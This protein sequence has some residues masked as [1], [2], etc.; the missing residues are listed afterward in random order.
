[1]EY[2]ILGALKK[3]KRIRPVRFHMPG[4]QANRRLFSFFKDLSMDITELSFSDCLEN[5]DG[6]IA[7]AEQEIAEILGARRSFIVTDGSSAAVFAMLFAARRFGSKIVIC[8]NS[9]KSVYNACALLGIEPYILK[10]NELDGVL[11]PPTP[12]DVEEAFKK[13]S[14]VCGV[15]LTSPD[16][17]G[18]IAEYE[19]IRKI[20]EKHKKLLMVDGAHGAYLKFDADSGSQAV[21]ASYAGD[22]ADIWVDG[23]HKTLPTLTQG[24]LLNVNNE[25]LIPVA[26]EG[27]GFFRT[28]SPSYPIMASVEYGVKFMAENGARLIDCI[29]RELT[30]VK[31]RLEKKGILFYKGS[32]TLQFAVD[33]GGMGISP[34]LAQEELEKR[35]FFAELNDGRYLV[36]YLTAATST[37]KLNRLERAI[38]RLVRGKT[39]KNTYSPKP[40]YVCGVKKFSY[41]T[42]L[43][44]AVQEV[45]LEKAVGKVCARNVGVT[46]PCYPLAIA[47]EVIGKEMAEY[48][49]QAKHTFGI[50]E[51]KIAVIKI[52]GRV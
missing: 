7:V 36:F 44:F 13:E 27:L 45:P 33:F 21:R 6:I 52:G 16:Y 40:E 23:A 38:R 10:A 31:S 15:L 48:L 14:D 12:L 50:K 30:L 42:A 5:P 11:L 32:S 17:Y 9:H 46:P 3:Y 1:M 20:C 35:G 37:A 2:R 26:E 41:L 24:A 34:Y 22:F 8:R 18:N 49:R 4:H 28:T 29:K 25:H 43:T 51:G 39:L 19:K 47:G